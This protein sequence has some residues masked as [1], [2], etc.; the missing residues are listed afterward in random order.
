MVLYSFE[1]EDDFVEILNGLASWKK[2]PLGYEHAMLYVFD[3]RQEADNICHKLYHA[4]TNYILHQKYGNKV[5]SYKRNA[6]TQWYMIYDWNSFHQVA[7]IN[8][9]L[10][11]HVTPI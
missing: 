11:N 6:Q 1:T 7:F 5:H 4:N 8:K 9:I 3:I 2:H 10:N